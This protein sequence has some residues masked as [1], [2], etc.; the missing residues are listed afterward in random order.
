MLPSVCTLDRVEGLLRSLLDRTEP[1]RVGSNYVG[2]SGKAVTTIVAGG[3]T[4]CERCEASPFRAGRCRLAITCQ[5]CDQIRVIEVETPSHVASPR[6]RRP[7]AIRSWW[8][9]GRF[10]W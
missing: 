5:V 3:Q 1:F 10:R 6:M 9:S 8:R 7:K 2:S 4:S